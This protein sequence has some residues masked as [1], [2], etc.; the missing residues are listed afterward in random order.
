M[1]KVSPRIREFARRALQ[2]KLSL[3]KNIS[4]DLRVY[5]N[6][7]SQSVLSNGLMPSVKSVIEDH[8]ERVASK[9]I[10]T[11]K[12][13][14]LRYKLVNHAVYNN[15]RLVIS[16]CTEIDRYTKELIARSKEVAREL[17]T[18]KKTDEKGNTIAL[19]YKADSATLNKTASKVLA[20]YNKN[21]IQ[22]IAITETNTLYES[23]N[24]DMFDQL[25][26]DVDAAID[27]NDQEFLDSLD[28]M[29]DSLTF[30][31]VRQKVSQGEDKDKIRGVVIAAMQTWITVGDDVVR[32]AHK[33][34]EGQ[35]VPVD[36]PF[37]CDGYDMYFP[38]DDSGGAPLE[39]WINC[40]CSVAR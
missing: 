37:N 5:F 36:E 24:N 10:R 3:E 17:L 11:G 39:L 31:E 27:D 22:G 19:E 20:N 8:N 9:L 2:K 23:A 28:D 29:Y 16:H 35:T 33:D 26:D 32:D 18:D 4:N 12:L 13:N 34:M 21:R 1:K 30:D 14:I 25:Q 7:V 40:R 38:G 15:K 6:R